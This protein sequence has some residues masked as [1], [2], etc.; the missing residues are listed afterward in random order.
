M[1]YVRKKIP[2]IMF[3]LILIILN[4]NKNA[5]NLHTIDEPS[6]SCGWKGPSAGTVEGQNITRGINPF[7]TG[8]GRP[9]IR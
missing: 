6:Y 5:T 2:L 9:V 3:E 1:G 7:F 8:D 4:S